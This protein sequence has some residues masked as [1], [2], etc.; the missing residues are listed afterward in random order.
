[1]L[2]RICLHVAPPRTTPHRTR[3]TPTTPHPPNARP[4]HPGLRAVLRLRR[5]LLTLQVEQRQRLLHQVPLRLQLDGRQ[6]LR[7]AHLQEGLGR[8]QAVQ[9][10]QVQ[11]VRVCRILPKTGLLDPLG[12]HRHGHLRP[13]E[14]SCLRQGAVADSG[15]QRS[16]ALPSAPRAAAALLS[17][18]AKT[19]MPLRLPS[20]LLI[21]CPCC[22]S[23]PCPPAVHPQR[24]PL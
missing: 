9:Q 10:G 14:L 15:G 21:L 12:P 20:R 1:M 13:G 16:P 19:L 7:K 6:L 11:N 23:S 17:S 22:A 3:Q 24:R 4:A 8:L 2:A 18:S 5:T